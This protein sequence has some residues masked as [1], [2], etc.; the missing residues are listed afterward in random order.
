MRHGVRFFFARIRRWSEPS[1]VSSRGRSRDHVK[2]RTWAARE[3]ASLNFSI[4]SD[5]RIYCF[6]LSLHILDPCDTLSDL[7]AAPALVSM[8]HDQPCI[9][10]YKV[11]AGQMGNA[12]EIRAMGYD[13]GMTRF[14][15][16]I[17]GVRIVPAGTTVDAMFKTV[18]VR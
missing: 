9:I 4:L 3:Q 15:H 6:V 10:T 11:V 12:H 16:P 18:A 7:K 1:S 2:N 14:D 13:T 17:L 8:F 5:A